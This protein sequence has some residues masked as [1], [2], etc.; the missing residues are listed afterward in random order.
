MAVKK[1]A[2]NSPLLVAIIDNILS[3]VVL[4]LPPLIIYYQWRDYIPATISLW[5]VDFSGGCGETTSKH[6][7]V[8]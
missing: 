5:H 3:M 2:Y 7:I 1:T 8:N 4:L 6:L